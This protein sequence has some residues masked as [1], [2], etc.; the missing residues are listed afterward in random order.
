V[1]A[2]TDSQQYTLQQLAQF[3][4]IRRQIAAGQLQAREALDELQQLELANVQVV[5]LQAT[6]PEIVLER[7]AKR[8]GGD[9]TLSP[10]DPL[11]NPP[12]LGGR[13]SPL[14]LRESEVARTG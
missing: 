1:S 13:E 10:A 12:P 3:T 6:G 7:I 9:P 4:R 14:S 11:P 5:S 8:R 2:L